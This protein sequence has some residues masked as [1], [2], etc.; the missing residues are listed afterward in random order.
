MMPP[1]F[2]LGDLTAEMAEVTNDV[3]IAASVPGIDRV[4]EIERVAALD[5]VDYDVARPLRPQSG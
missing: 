3:E 4:V 5:D 2:S 1:K